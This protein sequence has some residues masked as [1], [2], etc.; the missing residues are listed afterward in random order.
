MRLDKSKVKE[1]RMVKKATK[2]KKG[3]Q[4]DSEK[5]LKTYKT[6]KRTGKSILRNK[7]TEPPF[8]WLGLIRYVDV[9]VLLT[10]I[11]YAKKHL[12]SIIF[13]KFFL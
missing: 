8:G 3:V 10:L 9:S 13:I 2:N 1:N 12:L 4:N 11:L 6:K 5:H 7:K